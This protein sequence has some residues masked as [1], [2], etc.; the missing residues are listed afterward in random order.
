MKMKD[1]VFLLMAFTLLSSLSYGQKSIT[2]S[3]GLKTEERNLTGFSRVESVGSMN[4]FITKA[5]NFN[6]KIEADDSM[7]P[8]IITEVKGNTL[9]IRMKEHFSFRNTKKMDIYISMP[10]VTGLATKGSGSIKSESKFN[11][12]E[13]ELKTEGSGSIHFNFDGHHAEV[14]THGSGGISFT[15]KVNKTEL[16]TN[17][18]GSIDARLEC[19][20][21]NLSTNGSG[22]VKVSGSAIDV[23]A[24]VHGSGSID[25]FGF[26]CKKA[27]VSIQGSGNC[28]LSVSENLVG[29]IHGSGNIRCKGNA[30]VVSQNSSGSG[31]IRK[32]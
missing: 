23:R 31:K 11:G 27:D 19:E 32:E 13:L 2:G 14:A 25:G 20:S 22:S 5:D 29:Q 28:K 9:V 21:A 30:T 3:G 18:S 12:D 10:S 15:G 7:L 4:V 1:Y 24:A 26:N 17:G 6:V 16:S 8:Y